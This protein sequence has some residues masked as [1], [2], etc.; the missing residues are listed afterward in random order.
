MNLELLTSWELWAPTGLMG[1][2]LWLS[3]NVISTRLKAS[4]QHEFDQKLLSFNSELAD[5]QKELD[6]LRTSIL[7]N[8]GALAEKRVEAV[9]LLWKATVRLQRAKATA[10]IVAGTDEQAVIES[11]DAREAF[12]QMKLVSHEDVLT[13]D[14]EECR[15]FLSEFAW[16]LFA[17]YQTILLTSIV[18]YDG[19]TNGIDM[20]QFQKTDS[21]KNLL[22]AALPDQREFIDSMDVRSYFLLLEIL[23]R[24]LLAELRNNLSGADASAA[25]IEQARRIE[26]ALQGAN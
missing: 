16:S 2:V 8:Y 7:D 20:K 19:M 4:V 6:L 23:E 10:E 1:L 22:L 18:Q 25:A 5:K 14:I 15:P 17:A 9:S 11:P 26:K 21:I 3:K 12:R 13:E 24:R